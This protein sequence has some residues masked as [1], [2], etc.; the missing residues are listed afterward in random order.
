MAFFLS[1]VEVN[2][3]VFLFCVQVTVGSL[4]LSANKD[5]RQIVEIVEDFGKYGC[6]A[7]HLQVHKTR[8]YLR[9]MIVS[10][11]FAELRGTFAIFLFILVE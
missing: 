6:L 5:I 9:S 3:Y 8:V 4:E 11:F 2:S 1:P 7:R 10:M